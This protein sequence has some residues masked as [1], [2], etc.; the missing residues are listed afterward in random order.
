[1]GAFAT[2]EAA[3]AEAIIIA[4]RTIPGAALRFELDFKWILSDLEV[5]GAI[6]EGRTFPFLP[7]T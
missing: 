3:E 7:S 5:R 6:L 2:L 1:M 4:N